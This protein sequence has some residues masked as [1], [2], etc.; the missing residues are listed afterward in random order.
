MTLSVDLIELLST[1]E[2]V[3]IAGADDD[4]HNTITNADLVEIRILNERIEFNLNNPIYAIRCFQTF[5]FPSNKPSM[6]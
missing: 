3:P 4:D 5:Q 1:A 2:R 6:K